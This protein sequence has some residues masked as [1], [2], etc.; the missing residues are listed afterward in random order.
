MDAVLGF[1][2]D[3]FVHCDTPERVF[4]H[5]VEELHAVDL[6]FGNLEG[7]YTRTPQ[8]APTVQLPVYADPANARVLGPAGFTVMSLANNHILDCGHAAMLETRQ[9]MREQGIASAGVGA[10]LDEALAPAI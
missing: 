1:A 3:V 2:G 10:N 5:V 9:L 7:V 4:E 8:F 6:L